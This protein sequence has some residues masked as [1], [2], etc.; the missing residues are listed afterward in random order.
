MPRVIIPEN[1]H[2][3][4]LPS[5]WSPVQWEMSEEER[6]LELEAQATASLMHT[7]DA[8]EAMLR[9]V[10]D[11]VEIERVYKPPKGYDGEKQGEWDPDLVTFQFSRIFRM[12]AKEHKI[13][14]LYVEYKIEDLGYWAVEI[15]PEEVRIF[16][17]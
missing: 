13:D 12:I 4:D 8:P 1:F 16:R 10:L 11:E 17:L 5:L 15:K 2:V 7:I 3:D 9:L 14:Y 6:I